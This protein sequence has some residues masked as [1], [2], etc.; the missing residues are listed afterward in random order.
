MAK[1]KKTFDR[2]LM[3]NKIM[4]TN[5][6]RD[7]IE[8]NEANESAT[9]VTENDNSTEV[10]FQNKELNLIRDEK[11]EVILYNVTEKLVLD[12]LEATLKKMNC[13]RC[14]R[15]KEDIV[16]IALNNL[17]PKYIVANKDNIKEK[18]YE[19]DEMGREVTTEVIKAVLKVRKNPRH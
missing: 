11:N 5:L 12:K 17:K 2:E 15:C 16:A 10:I 8:Q 7:E 18:I 9:I 3:Y 4:P 6:K 19:Y 1:I 14:D 13:C